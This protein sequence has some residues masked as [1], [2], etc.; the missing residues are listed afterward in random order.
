[1][2]Q[3]MVRVIVVVAYYELYVIF[4]DVSI[5][6]QISNIVNHFL[7]CSY[8][9]LLFIILIINPRAYSLLMFKIYLFLIMNYCFWYDLK[10]FFVT[11][12]FLMSEQL[13]M[14]LSLIFIA[15]V[16]Y[17]INLLYEF[18]LS[19]LNNKFKDD[20]RRNPSYI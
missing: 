9:S 1:M 6:C 10:S 11:V 16:L 20:K 12:H 13:V 7:V 2:N 19:S 8:D 17:S 4:V 18:D 15:F 3:F 14:I 5:L